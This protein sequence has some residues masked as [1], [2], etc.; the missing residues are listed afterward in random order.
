MCLAVIL[1]RESNVPN[2]RLSCIKFS[3]YFWVSF[4]IIYFINTPI[5]T[6]AIFYFV[7]PFLRN[8]FA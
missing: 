3:L 7:E 1:G 8:F 5:G 6:L 4:Y 2:S